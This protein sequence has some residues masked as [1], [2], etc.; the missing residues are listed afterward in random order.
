MDTLVEQLQR[1]G[2]LKSPA[3]AHAMGAVDRAHFVPA[4]TPPDLAYTD[5]PLPLG[6]GETISAPHMHAA[7]LDILE[8]HLRPGA[9]VLD[10]GSGGLQS[11]TMH[12]SLLHHAQ[13]RAI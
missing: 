12:D 5:A 6:F 2:R 10:V 1:E 11:H 3:L 4:G 8:A 7:C 13:A 9:H